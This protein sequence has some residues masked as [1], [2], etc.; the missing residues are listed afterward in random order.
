[1]KHL[2]K[3][4]ESKKQQ[5]KPIKKVVHI[6]VEQPD[7]VDDPDEEILSDLLDIVESIGHDN[8]QFTLEWEEDDYPL[9]K[10]YLVRT[11]GPEIKNYESFELVCY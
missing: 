11:Y 10:D 5:Y 1:M 3:F 2:N 6:L 9:W 4:N 7:S 8:I